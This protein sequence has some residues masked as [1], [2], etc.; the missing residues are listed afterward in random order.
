[1]TQY[2]YYQHEI[3]L[4][5]QILISVDDSNSNC[6]SSWKQPWNR[7]RLHPLQHFSSVQTGMTSHLYILK[8]CKL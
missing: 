6:L 1:V 2:I 4:I 8:K 7:K 3:A 5:Q